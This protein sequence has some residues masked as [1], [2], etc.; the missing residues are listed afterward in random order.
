MNYQETLEYLFSRLPMYQRIGKAAYKADLETTH[1]LDEYFGHPH[2]QF[3][4]VHVAGTNGKGSVSHMLASVLQS[5]GHK[6]GLY[7]SPHLLDF[8]ERIRIDGA[9]VSREFVIEFT[10]QHQAVFEQLKPSFF[11][12]T[13]AMAFAYFAAEKVD[14]AII[15]TGMGGRLDSTNIITPLVSVITNIGL[16]HT[17]FLGSTLPEIAGE[18]AG[19]IKPGTPVVIGEMQPETKD[20]FIEAASR[21]GSKISFASEEYTCEFATRTKG[22]LQSLNLKATLEGHRAPGITGSGTETQQ[23]GLKGA[24]AGYRPS[25]L[26]R[27][28]AKKQPSQP[29][30]DGCTA[31]D[32]ENLETDLLGLYQ[33]KNAVAALHTID[34]LREQG[35]NISRDEV[36]TGMRQVVSA[37][38][39][40]GRWQIAGT[41]P[42]VVYDT[43]HNADGIEAVLLQIRETPH[44]HLHMVLG[45]VNDKNTEEILRMLP[46]GATFYFTMA[47]IPRS[48]D[49]AELYRRALAAGLSGRA[50][51]DVPDAVSAAL[52]AAGSDDLIFVGGSTFV[53]AD[54]AAGPLP[55]THT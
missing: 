46:A 24:G 10:S 42:L 29:T 51:P 52:A 36:Y 30:G 18:K 28:G 23:G 13:V 20:V 9:P 48:L 33:Q 38:G 2:R 54:A 5:A 3:S 34:I 32:W 35:V 16:D 6:T 8:R 44:K 12:M 25:G 26:N 7:T 14:I 21:S 50:Y 43:A 11:E 22:G 37:T 47:S 4:S 41:N 17:E 19:I 45:F 40:M 31:A 53:V 55:F 1:A 27:T 39:F 49:A 15:E